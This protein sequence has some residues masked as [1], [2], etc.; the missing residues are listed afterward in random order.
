VRKT[1]AIV[2]LLAGFMMQQRVAGQGADKIFPYPYET[3]DLENGLRVVVV[4]TDY[5]NLV[6]LQIPVLVGSRNE[7]EEGKSGFAHFF[8]H[9]MFRGTPRFPTE[10]YGEILKNAGADQNAFTTDDF[11]NYHTT[12]GKDDLDTVLM[13]EADRFQ[14]LGYSVEGFK[15]EARAV[16]GE[17]NKNVADPFEKLLESMREAAFTTHTY[18]HTTMGFLKDIERMPEQ[19]DYSRAFFDRYYRPERT[20]IVIAGDVDPQQTIAMVEKHWGAW[21][22]GGDVPPIPVEPA[23]AK[24]VR[25][26]VPWET[27]TL[28]WMVVG[29]HGPAADAGA[30]MAAMSLIA[31]LA[32]SPSAPLYQRLVVK[33]Q[34]VDQLF[35]MFEDHVDPE[36]LTVAARVKDPKDVAYVRDQIQAAF[37]EL[38]SSEPDAKRFAD[39][40]SH[41]RYSFA[42]RLDSSE[43][44]AAALARAVS[45]SR[46][47]ETINRRFALYER[48][49]AADARALAGRYFVDRGMVVVSLAHEKLDDPAMELGS[50][51]DKVVVPATRGDDAAFATVLQPSSSPLVNLRLAFKTGAAADPSGKEGLA[52]LTAAMLAE[53]GSQARTYDEIRQATFPLAAELGYQVDQEMTVF[54]AQVHRDNFAKFYELA[55]GQVFD[56]GLREDDFSRVKADLVNSIR[57]NLRA[58][59]DEELGKEALREMIYAGHPYGHLSRGHAGALEKL[60][61]ADVRD[62][63]RRH[64][65]RANV[66]LGLAGGYSEGDLARIT[67][68][69]RGLAG[70]DGRL[71][72]IPQA[73]PPKGVRVRILQKET[74]AVAISMGF[75]I[76]VNRAHP[77]FPA[78]WLARSWLGE[79]RSSTSHL[80]QRIREIRGLNYGDYAY[81]EYFPRGMFQFHPDPNLCRTRQIFEIWIRPVMPQSA[82]FALRAARFELDKLVR[83]GLAQEDF[84]A[85]R[86]F[87]VKFIHV[88]TKRQDS[89]LGYAMDSGWYG[90][91]E[92]GPWMTQ[93]LAALT[94]DDVN[95]AIKRHLGSESMSIVVVAKDAEDLRA[96][97]VAG[98][99]SP[100]AYD[101]AKPAAVLEEDKIIAT[102]DLGIAAER[103]EIVP[104]ETVFE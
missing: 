95:A 3:K 98:T 37:A 86:N 104:I 97:L 55:S 52:H 71:P 57:V 64:Y 62:F 72:A 26:H 67:T 102:Y 47:P 85:T 69:L 16:L 2:V 48:L 25:V 6:S 23:A 65:V 53:A 15:T 29:F 9:M 35:A 60:T 11:T 84:E 58:N 63:Y 92:L 45:R 66:I 74:R 90:I 19:F 4:R 91:P 8:E 76:D 14:N 61:I 36:L 17:Y 49:T 46:D 44:I 22:R 50:V 99:P 68:D 41:Q 59:N 78:L 51:D 89:R 40:K 93:K 21:R 5:P 7:V 28:P 24:P 96:R 73:S 42:H 10:K 75:P 30:D 101:A 12:F 81:I 13:L 80:Y 39:I 31:D 43:A 82:H 34:K 38:R 33:E 27:P 100:I 56:P 77:D 103:V 83:D 87:L 1:W 32:F 79:H 54:T 88:L 70:G 94:R 20:C 18:K